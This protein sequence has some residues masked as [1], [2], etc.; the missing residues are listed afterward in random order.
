MMNLWDRWKDEGAFVRV[1]D[2]IN[3]RCPRQA[4]TI[5]HKHYFGNST[6]LVTVWSR[7]MIWSI[8]FSL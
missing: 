3:G 1:S 8:L 6:G 2:E 7:S 4:T 5:A